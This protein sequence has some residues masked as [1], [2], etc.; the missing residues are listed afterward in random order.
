MPFL[1]PREE[2]RRQSSWVDFTGHCLWLLLLRLAA[3]IPLLLLP[4]SSLTLLDLTP[5]S[6]AVSAN[7]ISL[8]V[9]SLSFIY[10]FPAIARHPQSSALFRLLRMTRQ[11]Q[12]RNTS[13]SV[14]VRYEHLLQ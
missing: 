3:V 2:H 7:T 6:E 14:P 9:S 4:Q 11:F 10:F 5:D 8:M 12:K 13:Q 1:W